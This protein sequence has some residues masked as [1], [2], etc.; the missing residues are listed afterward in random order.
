MVRMITECRYRAVD[1]RQGACRHREER[2]AK[3]AASQSKVRRDE[4]I[5]RR[6]L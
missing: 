3:R 5:S 6:S 4:G 1:D 2:K